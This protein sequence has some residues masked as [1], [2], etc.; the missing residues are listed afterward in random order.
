MRVVPNMVYEFRKADDLGNQYHAEEF[1]FGNGTV[2][3]DAQAQA[4]VGA[5]AGFTA[6]SS[7]SS[8][9]AEPSMT[10]LPVDFAATALA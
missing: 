1:R 4:L 9:S 8:T 7:A 10:I 6:G 5:M 3:T 2:L